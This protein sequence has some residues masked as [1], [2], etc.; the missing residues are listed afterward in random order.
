MAG[1]AVVVDSNENLWNGGTEPLKAS[2][3]KLMMWFFLL[4][5]AFTFT[6]LLATYGFIRFAHPAF[7]GEIENFVFSQ[8][9]W[10]IPEMVF[11]AVPFLHGIH[12]PLVFVGIMT[13]I[14][15]LSSVT[16]VLAVDAGHR[17]DKVAVEKWMLWT[18]LGGLT[19]LGC[20]AW[21]WMHFIHGTEAGGQLLDGSFFHGANLSLNQYGPPNFAAL[22]FFIT[23]FHGFH[24]FS[25]VVINFIIF[26]Q[27]TTGVLERRGTYEMVEKVGLYWHFVDLVWVFVFTFFYLV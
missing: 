21:E 20:Q 10:P 1:T 8:E 11:N 26:Y 16:M 7:E 3:G 2:Y 18:I 9:Y 27:A 14:L 4:S 23:G 17:N 15:I 22:F 19:F 6:S 12:L 13:F 25:G 24:V 5:D